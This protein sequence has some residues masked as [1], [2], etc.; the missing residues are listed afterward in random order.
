MNKDEISDLKSLI[1]RRVQTELALLH[2]QLANEEAVRQLESFFGK[3]EMGWKK[4]PLDD[5]HKQHYEEAIRQMSKRV[6]T[7][8][9]NGVFQ[10]MPDGAV[11]VWWLEKQMIAPASEVMS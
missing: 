9:E 11:P 5:S 8:D 6:W 2:A 1:Q 7:P 3:Q 10:E 4:M